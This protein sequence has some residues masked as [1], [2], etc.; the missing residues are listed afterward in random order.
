M[1]LSAPH[2]RFIQTVTST[3]AASGYQPLEFPPCTV[4]GRR[5]TLARLT[6]SRHRNEI[7][8]DDF[9][10]VVIDPGKHHGTGFLGAEPE[11]NVRVG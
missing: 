1:Y 9:L 6:R 4:S 3:L 7:L 5:M 2:A 11:L 10:A 8:A